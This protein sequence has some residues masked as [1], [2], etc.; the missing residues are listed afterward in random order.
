MAAVGTVTATK[1]TIGEGG[2][3]KYS[4]A[5]VSDA[6]G[7]VSGTNVTIRTGRWLTVRFIP[8][9]GGTAPTNLYDLTFEDD[10]NVD[11]LAG[12]G[13]NLSATV[14][15]DIDESSLNF[16]AGG[17]YELVIANA[18]NAKGGTVEIIVRDGGR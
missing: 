7:V 8:D 17:A 3:R 16:L 11:V 14:P 6:A 1:T 9:G 12:G 5:W 2:L 15:A 10:Q 18:G 13:A 4:L